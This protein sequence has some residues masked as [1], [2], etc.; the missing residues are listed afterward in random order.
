MKIRNILIFMLCLFITGCSSKFHTSNSESEAGKLMDH[1][2]MLVDSSAYHQAAQEYALVAERYPSTSY[3]KLAVWKAGMLN[4]HPDNPE[5]D[6]SAALYWLQIYLGLPLSPDEKEAATVYVSM[7]EQIDTVQSE[8]E[9]EKAK[10]FEITQKQSSDNEAVSQRLKELEAELSKAKELEAELQTARDE[11]EKMKAVDVRMHQSKIG[12]IDDK[13]VKSI[14]KAPKLKNEQ[15]VTKEPDRQKT[16]PKHPDFYP[17]MI[18][19]GSYPNKDESMREAM[20]LRDKGDSV[21]ISHV[22]ISGKGDWYRV[23][24]GYYQ[25]PEEAQRAVLELKKREYLNAFVV[26]RPF[27][28]EV[29]IFSDDKK[30]NEMAADLM[31]KGY[32]AYRVPD[33]VYK[34]KIRLLVGAFRAEEEAETMTK[35]LQKEGFNPKVVRR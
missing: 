21:C 26:K 17:Y 30:L 19:V 15:N 33:G 13:P 16:P 18:Q 10:L 14:Q 23:L 8:L 28:I 12:Q 4:I 5:T 6:Y 11:L 3:H 7:I 32:S 9:I 31:A 29:G 2:A 20:I 27:A 22:H 1:A 24:V 25:T 34:N 35:S